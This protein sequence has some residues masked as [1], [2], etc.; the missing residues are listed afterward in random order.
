MLARL[1]YVSEAIEGIT[2]ADVEK[3][4]SLARRSNQLHDISGMLLFNRESFLQVIEGDAEVLTS[5]YGRISKDTRH[6]RLKLLEFGEVAQRLFDEW[7]M[8]FAGESDSNRHVFL[9]HTASSHFK[10][11]ELNAGRALALLLGLARP[12]A[13]TAAQA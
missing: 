2:I 7:S 12:G 9:R 8:Q 3:I 5:L 10:P 1:I 11:Y 13:V 4:L 6:R